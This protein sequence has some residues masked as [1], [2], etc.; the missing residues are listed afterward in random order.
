MPFPVFLA[1]AERRSQRMLA[2][3]LRRDYPEMYE[4]L[5]GIARSADIPVRT[6][7][8]LNALEAFMSCV[9]DSTWVPGPSA[10]SAVAV[11]GS[12]SASGHPIIARNFDYLPTVRPYYVLRETRPAGGL[13]SLDFTMAPLAGAVD[14]VNEAG[15]CITYNYAFTTDRS[16]ASTPISCS[17]AEALERCS[18]VPQ[19]AEWIASRPRWGGGILMLADAAGDIASLELSS[20]RSRLIRPADGED[21]LFH[22]NC[23]VGSDMCQVEVVPE[24]MF[25]HRAPTALRGKLVLQSAKRRRERFNDLLVA[26]A[27][28]APEDLLQIMADHGADGSPSDDS[29]CMHGSYWQTTAALQLFPHE[30]KMRVAYTS[31]CQA[32]FTEVKLSS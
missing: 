29:I 9:T 5:L 23:F 25:D 8:L 11:R 12:R 6:L 3:A 21:I 28:F 19:A 16:P 18:T 32:E 24:T 10:C 20:T 1:L 13:R 31:A 26:R 14:G 30:R 27:K 2:A 7:F 4:R 22:T 15:L 17:I